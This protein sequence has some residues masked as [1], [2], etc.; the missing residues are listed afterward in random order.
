MKRLYTVVLFALALS[1][2]AASKEPKKP[3][4]VKEKFEM[5]PGKYAL[6]IKAPCLKQRDSENLYPCQCVIE[7]GWNMGP[8]TCEERAEHLTSTYSNL[9]NGGSSTLSCP[10]PTDWAWCYGASCTPDPKDPSKLAICK[11]PMLTSATVILTSTEKCGDTSI[12]RHLWSGA[13]PAESKFANEYYAWWM[14][15]HS[16]PTN[17]AAPACPTTDYKK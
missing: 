1:A 9:F 13:L 2:V 5:C 4:D 8:N 10:A 11:C 6:C 12:C 17:P 16:H 3:P 15:Q 14:N 7:S